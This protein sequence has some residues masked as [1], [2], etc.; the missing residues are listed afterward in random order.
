[1]ADRVLHIVPTLEYT[2]VTKQM[3]LLTQSL[4]SHGM[5]V[6]VLS[7]APCGPLRGELQQIGA[8]VPMIL[9]DLYQPLRLRSFL[10]K[11]VIQDRTGIVHTWD[12]SANDYGRLLAVSAGARHVLA[13]YQGPPVARSWPRLR[14]DGQ[15]GRWTRACIVN[16]TVVRDAYQV[17][18]LPDEKWTMI[19]SGVT[20]PPSLPAHEK[21]RLM[22]EWGVPEHAK[23]V[24]VIGR[25]VPRKRI[26]DLIWAAEL[27]QNLRDD[28]YVLIIGDGPQRGRLER[29]RNQVQVC[30]RVRFLG[31]RVDVPRCVRAL[32]CVWQAGH[33]EGISHS[34]LEAMAAGV[35]VIAS[36][37]AGHRELIEPDETGQLVRLG[38]RGGFARVTNEI[39]EDPA[40]AA[41]LA[42]AAR[43]SVRDRFNFEEMVAQ[44]LALYRAA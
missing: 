28:V 22:E 6:T 44:H 4:C 42:N 11:W 23:L 17:L 8:Q 10:R 32:D 26:K 2:G 24:G 31:G 35:T 39:L 12:D 7:L 5:D 15:L 25:L 41:R 27:L 43:E 21:Q 1:M 19:P 16:S 13:S 36:D 14:L 29:Y 20:S 30:E 33:D 9:P 40:R 34:V 18:R 38:D 37:T 3:A